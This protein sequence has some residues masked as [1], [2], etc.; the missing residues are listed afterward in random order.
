MVAAVE[1]LAWTVV[2]APFQG[3]DEA[4]HFAYTQYLA[5]TGHK[6][7]FDSGGGSYSHEMD[8][9]L[10][11]LNL[12]TLKRQGTARPFWT[13]NELSSWKRSQAAMTAADR[14]NGSGPNAIAKNPPL[15]YALEAIPYKVTVALGANPLTRLFWMRL[16]SG[17][18]FLAAVAFTWFAAAELFRS[19]FLRTLAAATV[20]LLPLS[21][22]IGASLNPDALLAALFAGALLAGLR[23]LQRGFSALR[24]VGLL[25]LTAAALLT[26]G[27]GLP[28][29]GF[30]AIALA[31]AW[32]RHRPPVRA[33]VIRVGIGV[34]VIAAGFAIYALVLSGSGGGGIYGGE[35]RFARH[36]SPLQFASFVWQFYLPRLPFM[37][38]RPGPNFGFFEFYVQGY[39]PGAFGSED[40]RWSADVYRTAHLIVL[41]GVAGLVV[42]AVSMRERL[43]ARWDAALLVVCFV[44]VPVLF[45]HLASY[46]A[47]IDPGATDALIVGRYLVPLTPALGLA[48]AFAVRAIRRDGRRAL[49][50]GAVLGCGVLLQLGALG[51]T[52]VR[53][54]G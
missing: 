33:A 39:L 41:L 15:Y 51:L 10:G 54:Y 16:F 31:L 22:E 36:F 52:A 27:R 7:S 38:V 4:A 50:A 19:P 1:V 5:E 3:P 21:S 9:L 25:A 53:F 24:V 46:R 2:I 8:N 6:P 44:V 35:L 40:V 34:A 32:Y 30:T 26:H 17:L 13:D 47:V 49:L 23:L 11:A 20:A 12:Y 43:A 42:A 28:L 29:L 48:I 14:S 18:F 45:L 37:G